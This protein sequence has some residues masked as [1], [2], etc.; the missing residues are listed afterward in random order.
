MVR[1]HQDRSHQRA[2]RWWFVLAS[3]LCLGGRA[4]AAEVE[5]RDFT[6]YV[7]SKKAGDVHM[8]INRQDDGATSVSCDTDVRVG[9]FITLYRYS[10]R[11][12]E[13]WK[14]GVLQRFESKSND[15]GKKYT[16]TAA[17]AEDGLHVRVNDVEHIAPA[18]VCLTSYW[19]QPDAK[20]ANQNMPIL[21][22]DT[23]RDLQAKVEFV[24]PEKYGAEG[25]TVQHV[26]LSGKG[27]AMDLWFDDAKR[28]VRQEWT[29]DGH[30]TL[31]DLN[32]VRR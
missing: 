19:M 6:V 18:E 11:G 17:K 24:G 7:D 20:L 2:R 4:G 16:V 8:T 3:A 5:T 32:R 31:V 27:V 13:Q 28:L 29:E 22:A 26:R 9:A 23:G 1:G 10:Y 15:N 30:R 12:M 21:D 25:Q 14:D